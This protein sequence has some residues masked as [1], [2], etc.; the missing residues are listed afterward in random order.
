MEK[1]VMNNY[2][3]ERFLAKFLPVSK[4]QL[5]KSSDKITLNPPFVLKIISNQALH[6]T[7]I[8]GVRIIRDSSDLNY[9]FTDLLTLAKK[10]NMKLQGILAQQFYEG[11]QLI[12]GIKKDPT[13]GHV[14]MFGMGGIF[15][16]VLEDI[17]IR[18][19][20]ITLQDA[21]EMIDEL[22][23]KKIFHGFR[24]KKLNTDLLKDVLV[25]V[26]KIPGKYRKIE[27]MDINPFILNEKEGRVVDA[28]IVFGS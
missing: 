23:A 7:E 26:S 28:R 18:K 8:K 4:S 24:G 16:E 14:I 12:I 11:E 21:E 9:E 2:T 22:K 6:K 1:K 5:V 27:E 19:C 10:K 25:K 15:A 3:A 13:F 20:P 17:S